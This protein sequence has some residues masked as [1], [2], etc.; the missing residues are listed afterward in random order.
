[1]KSLIVLL[2]L[3]MSTVVYAGTTPDLDFWLE[4]KGE[5]DAGGKPY[6]RVLTPERKERLRTFF[7][8]NFADA[9]ILKET[10]ASSKS[11]YVYEGGLEGD[12]LQGW[13]KGELHIT[14]EDVLRVLKTKSPVLYGEINV[15]HEKEVRVQ[16]EH[17][18]KI[19][20][21]DAKDNAASEEH[22]ARLQRMGGDYYRNRH[23]NVIHHYK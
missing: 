11:E 17:K 12:L 1:M 5:K 19:E 18:R 23:V 22:R 14:C 20:E 13:Y 7:I 21:L 8:E 9:I 15:A 6:G 16:E 3:L 2:L 4:Y 10:S